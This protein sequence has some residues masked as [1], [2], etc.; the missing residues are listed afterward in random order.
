MSK[1][2]TRHIK[3]ART[4]D[5]HIIGYNTETRRWI[6][7][8]EDDYSI[9]EMVKHLQTDG[10]SNFGGNAQAEFNKSTPIFL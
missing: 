9:K 5:D 1:R 3:L 4:D 7:L 8:H 2:K 10:V 6:W